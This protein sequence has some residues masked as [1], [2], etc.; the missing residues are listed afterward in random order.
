M[1]RVSNMCT[2]K[3]CLKEGAGDLFQVL[4]KELTEVMSIL[5][6]FIHSGYC[7]LNHIIAWLFGGDALGSQ[8][9]L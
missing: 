7:A 9:Q 4:F 5:Y 8:P 1:F 3:N 6:R 2:N